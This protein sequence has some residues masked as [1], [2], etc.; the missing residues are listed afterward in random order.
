M[1]RNSARKP[2]RG[3]AAKLAGLALGL[4]AFAGLW[5]AL[6]PAGGGR[7]ADGKIGGPFTLVADDGRTV[8][9]QSFPGKY[10]IVYFGYTACHDVC[11][12]TMN[13]LAAA[14][15]RLGDRAARVQPLFITLDPR[16]DNPAVLHRFVRAFT[17]RL[18]GLTGTPAALHEA[19]DAYR[20]VSV[21][22]QEGGAGYAL[23]HSSVLFLMGPD[24]RLI[25]PV[26]AGESEAMMAQTIARYL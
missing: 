16:R 18:I 3:E 13:T 8:T 10:L 6:E 1:T 11:P 7:A 12:A 24:G 26:P 4:L 19:A 22:H 14:M 5:I 23:D 17:P 9:D 2:I 25:A 21:L 20:I 15:G